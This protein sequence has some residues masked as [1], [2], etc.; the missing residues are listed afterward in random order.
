MQVGWVALEDHARTDSESAASLD[1]AAWR[2]PPAGTPILVAAHRAR[3]SCGRWMSGAHYNGK[4]ERPV[5]VGSAPRP[6]R[7]RVI[8]EGPS[9]AAPE[10]RLLAAWDFSAGIESTVVTDRGP[11]ARHGH[12]VN[13][14]ARGGDRPK[15]GRKRRR[16]ALRAG[17]VW[18]DPLPRGRPPRLP[19][20]DRHRRRGAGGLEKRLLRRAHART[21]GDG[22]CRLLRPSP[23]RRGE[24]PRR[25]RRFD[26][27]L[28]VLRQHPHQVRQSEHREPLREP[29]S[30]QRGRAV[31]ERTPRARALALRHARGRE[32]G[33]STPRASGPCSTSGPGSTPS[34]TSTT[35]TSSPG[36]R[37]GGSTST[38]SPTKT[39]TPKERSCSPATGW[40]SPVRTPSTRRRPCGMPSTPT[41]APAAATCTSA[42]TGSIG[43]SHTATSCPG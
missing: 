30:H 31:P 19:V 9:A 37:R 22:P 14:P 20:V 18:R 16:L 28:H 41:S 7:L 38:S 34:T 40:S 35:P 36:S 26:R 32:R 15:V 17:T 42:E 4:V 5:I 2:A 24:R 39:S 8:A 29:H 10:E 21:R 1:G 11:G 25:A 33:L 3:P 12:T 6:E 27:H 13:L 23:A 43:A